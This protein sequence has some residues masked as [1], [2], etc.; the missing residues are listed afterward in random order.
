MIAF[1]VSGLKHAR[2]HVRCALYDDADRWLEKERAHVSSAIVGSTAV[3]RFKGVPEGTYAIA[4]FH[5]EDDDGELDK[6][7]GIPSEP[8]CFSRDARAPFGPPT[9][10]A[11]SFVHRGFKTVERARA[12]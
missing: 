10:A 6:V 8:Y 1:G 7:L 12:R 2:G 5:D 4:A 11:A 3:C 9:F